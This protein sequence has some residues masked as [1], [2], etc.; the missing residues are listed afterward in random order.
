MLVA[1]VDDQSTT[2]RNVHRATV[3]GSPRNTAYRRNRDSLLETFPAGSHRRGEPRRENHP[4]RLR[5]NRRPLIAPWTETRSTRAKETIKADEFPDLSMENF[6]RPVI[7]DGTFVYGRL[8]I[9][10]F[11]PGRNLS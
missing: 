8:P 10:G 4:I 6:F 9:I 2:K 3:W 5:K 11:V 1:R 7:F